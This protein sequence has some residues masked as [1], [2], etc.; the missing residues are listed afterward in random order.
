MAEGIALE[1]HMRL[2]QEFSSQGDR[3]G[4]MAGGPIERC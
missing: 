2:G 4:L 3:A 1:G